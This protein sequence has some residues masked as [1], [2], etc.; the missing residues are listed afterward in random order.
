MKY[1]VVLFVVLLL[2]CGC[3]GGSYESQEEWEE[4]QDEQ[5]WD[6][7]SYMYSP[8]SSDLSAWV[9]DYLALNQQVQ[10]I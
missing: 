4:H 10:G 8:I 1:L 2:V 6:H 5:D 9:F 3:S 7:R